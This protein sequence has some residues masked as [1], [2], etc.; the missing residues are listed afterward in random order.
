MTDP[1]PLPSPVS[2]EHQNA[3]AGSDRTPLPPPPDDLPPAIDAEP[4]V[5]LARTPRAGEFT[6]GWRIITVLT[7]VGVVLAMATVWNT[8][9]QLGLSTWW[10][11][12]RGEPQPKLIQLSPFV[13]PVLMIL[14]T[15]NNARWLAWCGLAVSGVLAGYGLGDLGRVNQIAALELIIAG[16]AMGVS[17]A[18]LTRTYRPNPVAASQTAE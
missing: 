6:P 14:G 9:V 12:P 2:G 16:V 13:G 5:Y 15:I 18:S 3:V 17:I 10:L 8:S 11:G 1:S 4:A 7:W